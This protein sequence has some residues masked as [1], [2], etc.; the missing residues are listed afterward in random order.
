MTSEPLYHP[1]LTANL[2][3]GAN[4]SAVTAILGSS[5]KQ[6]TI[7]GKPCD[8]FRAWDDNQIVQRVAGISKQ[9]VRCN[10]DRQPCPSCRESAILSSGINRNCG[11]G[12]LIVHMMKVSK[13]N[14]GSMKSN[15]GVEG[16]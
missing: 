10:N 9:F 3:F 2:L 5:S 4:F 8:V 12:C 15:G 11:L 6:Q 7:W 14:L 16:M 13:Q 1:G